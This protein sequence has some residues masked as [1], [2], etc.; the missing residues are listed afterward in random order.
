[1]GT[2][3]KDDKFV[4]ITDG[5]EKMH[6][7]LMWRDA[8]PK[9]WQPIAPGKDRRIA[10]EVPVTFG[11]PDRESSVSEQSVLI[12]GNAAVVVDNA[13][14]V[15]AVAGALL[16]LVRPFSLLGGQLDANAPHGLER[17]DWNPVTRTCETEWANTEVS[18]PNGIP[19]M[20]VESGLIYDIGQKDNEW[21]LTGVDFDTG[22]EEMFVPSGYE[23]DKNSFFAGAEIGPDGSVWSGTLQGV[24]A[25]RPTETR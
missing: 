21:G 22:K 13:H 17:I 14:K 1:M 7:V 11:D 10:C 4:V 25:F 16:Q 24:S 2:G 20:S 9:D 23:P 15:D 19:T 6:L 12:R 3:R 8:I 5:Q 18:M